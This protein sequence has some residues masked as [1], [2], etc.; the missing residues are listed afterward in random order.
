LFKST[1]ADGIH[2]DAE[3]FSRENMSGIRDDGR[4]GH[5]K[6]EARPEAQEI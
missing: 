4:L 2:F 1:E 6:L 3:M 5:P